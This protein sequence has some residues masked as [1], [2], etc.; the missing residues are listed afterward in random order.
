[1][2]ELGIPPQ[3]L[4]AEMS[5]LS[6]CLLHGSEIAEIID[7]LNP[8]DF[9]RTASGKIFNACIDLHKQS[10]PVD[11]LTVS[12]ALKSSG[13]LIGCGGVS[14]LTEIAN[15]YPIATSPTHTAKIIKTKAVLRRTIELSHSLRKKCFDGHTDP[16]EILNE[17]LLG[18]TSIEKSI[19]GDSRW[20]NIGEVTQERIEH[21]EKISTGRSHITGVPSGF[22]D[23]DY[24]TSGFQKSDFII[25]A[26]RPSMGKTSLAL[27]IADNVS[28][29]VPI[30]LFSLEQPI[31]QLFDR[32]VASRAR[33][34]MQRIRTG[35]FGKGDW[36]N[37]SEAVGCM[38]DVGLWIDDSPGLHYSEIRR[39]ARQIVRKCGVRLLIIDYLQ[40]CHGDGPLESNECITSISRGFKE[41][42]KELEVPVIALSQLNRKLEERGGDKKRP[43]LSDLRG[44]GSLE[45]DADVVMFLYRDEV[46]N[47]DENNPHKGTAELNIAKHRNGPTGM[48]KL[49]WFEQFTRFED[50]SWKTQ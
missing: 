49:K 47:Q 29:K 20:L 11:I 19:S 4:E 31:S 32:S 43:M 3:N 27:N 24:I 16:S 9:Y 26:A 33:V 12:E 39:R 30:G 44:S 23:L 48:V 2:D 37:I 5:I 28:E 50:L 6:Y 45:Q 25:L 46:Y 42:A 35:R 38:S 7:I 41:I 21:Y 13:D 40:L 15:D 14:Y 1:M 18:I 34:N 22:V 17:A 36:I 10:E 8:G